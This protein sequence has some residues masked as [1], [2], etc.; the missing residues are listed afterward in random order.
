MANQVQI[1]QKL[2]DYLRQQDWKKADYETAFIMCQWMVIENY[3]DFYDLFRVVSLDVIN[4][5]DRLWMQY[6]NQQFGIKGQAKI[7]RDLG[8]TERYNEEIWDRFGDR[9][10]W[11]KG[12]RWLELDEV[13]YHTTEPINI[14][15]LPVLMYY[16]V[17]VG[18]LDGW[19]GG[20]GVGWVGWGGTLLSRQDLRGYSI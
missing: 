11:K 17:R 3:D 20:F 5:I 12:G 4:E 15:N 19:W 16:R 10:G 14:N 8:G 6:S 13:A 7:Y 2:E 9:V 18:W 1:Y